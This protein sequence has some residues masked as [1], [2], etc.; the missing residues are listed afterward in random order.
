M[1]LSLMKIDEVRDNQRIQ[2]DIGWRPLFSHYRICSK[3]DTFS[4]VVP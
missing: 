1:H 4:V 3:H 2:M